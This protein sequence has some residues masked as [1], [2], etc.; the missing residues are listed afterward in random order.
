MNSFGTVATNVILP[1]APFAG[2]LAV[3]VAQFTFV[4]VHFFD[5]FGLF[6]VFV[7]SLWILKSGFLDRFDLSK[8]LNPATSAAEITI[9]LEERGL[10]DKLK[11]GPKVALV[12]S[13]TPPQMQPSFSASSPSSS[14]PAHL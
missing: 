14:P 11:S 10:T 3:P 7:F 1:A 6:D 13:P 8:V 4:F 2:Q 5:Q 9:D 12:T